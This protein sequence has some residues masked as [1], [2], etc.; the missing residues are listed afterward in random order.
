LQQWQ[1]CNAKS[2]HLMNL[3][4]VMTNTEQHVT[5]SR[6]GHCMI[7]NLYKLVPKTRRGHYITWRTTLCKHIW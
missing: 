3:C 6:G 1:A 2:I 5:N 7:K 4:A